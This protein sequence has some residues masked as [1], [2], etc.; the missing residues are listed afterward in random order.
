MSKKEHEVVVENVMQYVNDAPEEA[1][2]LISDESHKNAKTVITEYLT[3]K[4]GTVEVEYIGSLL[5]YKNNYLDEYNKNKLVLV[6]HVENGIVPGGWYTY[7]ASY[8]EM[9][10]MYEVQEDGTISKKL[11]NEKGKILSDKESDYN[12]EKLPSWPYLDEGEPGYFTYEG[13]KYIGH[14]TLEECLRMVD[15]NV[16]HGSENML[17]DTIDFGYTELVTSES[18]QGYTVPN[19]AQKAEESTAVNSEENTA[20]NTAENVEEDIIESES[21]DTTDYGNK[22][23]AEFPVPPGTTWDPETCNHIFGVFGPDEV[24]V[25]GKMMWYLEDECV[26]CGLCTNGRYI[27]MKI[28]TETPTE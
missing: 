14:Q 21:Q 22:L 28:N 9:I 26:K 11:C 2:E 6:Y 10:F 5:Y 16:I 19:A 12:L 13:V 20:E 23:Y 17:G 1:L 24:E 25:D 7:A 3:E 18:L 4:C 8:D 27:E 15:V